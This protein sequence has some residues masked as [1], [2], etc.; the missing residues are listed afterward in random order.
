ML[1]YLLYSKS[2]TVYK[3]AQDLNIPYTAINRIIKGTTD[4]NKASVQLLVNLSKYLHLSMD[5]LYREYCLDKDIKESQWNAFISSLQH[6]IKETGAVK[7][8]RYCITSHI[9]EKCFFAK[10]Y[11]KGLYVVSAVDYLCRIKNIPLY[12]GYSEMRKIKLEEARFPDDIELIQNKELKEKLKER[13][14][15]ECIPEFSRANI[16][17]KGLDHVI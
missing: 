8:I 4:L 2:V 3:T 17:E 12:D 1:E 15:K 14:I 11:D 9:A 10:A 6:R 7:F 13:C 5:D 16:M